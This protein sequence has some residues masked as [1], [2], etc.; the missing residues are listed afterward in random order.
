MLM[1]IYVGNLT[2]IHDVGTKMY[3]DFMKVTFSTISSQPLLIES[4]LN[5]F[6]KSY[7]QKLYKLLP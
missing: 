6:R 4:L 5:L 7:P 3:H 2:S 1:L